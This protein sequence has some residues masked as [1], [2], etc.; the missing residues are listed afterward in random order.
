MTKQEI[1]NAAFKV[2][3]RELYQ[4]MSLTQLAR[5][6]GVSKPALYRHF[7]NKQALLEG[8]YAAFF[9]EYTA[10][11]K[12]QYDKAV[13]AQDPAESLFMMIRV[14]L[15]YYIHHREAFI[16]SLVRLSGY[17][18]MRNMSRQML[19]R[20]I[21]MSCFLGIEQ[22]PPGY[23]PL[24]Q[25]I[26]GMLSF[27]V[28]YF[29]KPDHPP[30]EQPSDQKV[31]RFISFVEEKTAAGLG[32]SKEA[33]HGLDYERLEKLV[34][35]RN[36]ESLEDSGILKAIAGAVAEAGP[37]NASM[38]MV[39]RRSGLSK[40]SLYSHFKNKQDML[41]RLFVTEFD[42]IVGYIEE[43]VQ[44][45]S[46]P[47][48][49]LY[50]A[51]FSVADYLRGRSEILLAADWIRTRRFAAEITVPRRL[52]EVFLGINLRIPGTE[53]RVF[54]PLTIKQMGLMILFL[55]VHTLMRRPEAMAFSD[56]PDTSVRRLFAFIALGVK[57]FKT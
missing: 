38:D 57:G 13:A 2:W 18:D 23:P 16:F 22:E 41:R 49:Q 36:Y 21:D 50:L 24:I 46:V 37:W 19:S 3:G 33:I 52:Y 44:W 26:I 54:N 7:K 25:L 12:P 32:L 43:S 45:S 14:I 15:N 29:H 11:I 10:F 30:E 20:G 35:P 40:S 1:I 55:I 27:F 31:N 5:G 47:E 48:E 39:A 17:Q 8:M 9:D 28:G 51:V 6:L 53:R 4:S 56:V 42:R 34:R